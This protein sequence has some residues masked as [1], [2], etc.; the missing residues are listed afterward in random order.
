LEVKWAALG[1]ILALAD[2]GGLRRKGV[3]LLGLI[4][5]AK[6][7]VLGPWTM[8]E[9]SLISPA[10]P[11]GRLQ[12]PYQPPAEYDVQVEVLRQGDSNSLNLGLVGTAGQFMVILDGVVDGEFRSGLDLVDGKSF[13]ANETLVRG[14]LVSRGRPTAVRVSVRK[15]RVEVA[16]DGKPALGGAIDPKRL[17]LYKDWAVPEK[18]CLLIGSWTGSVQIRKLELVPR[19]GEGRAL[20][21]KETR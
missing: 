12:I 18:R 5:P 14:E 8:K 2:S 11:F 1:V 3:D 17:T 4:D 16:V 10:R 6:D 15:D 20:R 9:G 13:Y 21:G 7:A 19:S